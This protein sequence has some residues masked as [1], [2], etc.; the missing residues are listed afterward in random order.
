MPAESAVV[1]ETPAALPHFIIRDG[2]YLFAWHH[3]ARPIA[4]RGAAVILC[5]PLGSDYICA[6]RAWRRLAERLASMGFDV[7]RFDYEGTG[8]SSGDLE[9]PC[10]VRAWLDN[11]EQVITEARKLTGSS[12]VAL[13]GLRIGAVL[14]LHAAAGRGGVDR[15]VLWSAFRSGRAYVRELKALSRLSRKDY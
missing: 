12:E 3:P 6:Y 9:E 13:V 8:G 4:R 2:G 14:A 7:L 5:P 15:L 10:R 11:I 1:A